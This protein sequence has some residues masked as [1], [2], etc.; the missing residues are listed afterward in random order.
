MSTT[1]KCL[2]SMDP[3]ELSPLLKCA[4]TGSNEHLVSYDHVSDE[5]FLFTVLLTS[6]GTPIGL[7]F[8][9]HSVIMFTPRH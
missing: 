9:G 7:D 4:T 5:G 2:P 8:P 1:P 3:Y 6:E